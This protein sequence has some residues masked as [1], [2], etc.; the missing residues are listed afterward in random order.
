[1]DKIYEVATRTTHIYLPPFLE[2]ETDDRLE[3]NQKAV[4]FARAYQYILGPLWGKGTP[5]PHIVSMQ[6]KQKK[7]A[8]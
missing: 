5:M 6:A 4:V 2:W 3:T 7:A 1:M 8:R